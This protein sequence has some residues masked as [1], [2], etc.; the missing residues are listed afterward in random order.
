MEII[1]NE[2]DQRFST[3]Q[4]GQESYMTY[5]VRADGT[6]VFNYSFTPPAHRGQ[7]IGRDL[8]LY[9]RDYVRSR[10]IPYVATCPFVAATLERLE[11]T[12]NDSTS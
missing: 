9:A 3:V 11:A 2:K 1:H 8:V 12:P 6:W 7:G 10:N 5:R 4:M